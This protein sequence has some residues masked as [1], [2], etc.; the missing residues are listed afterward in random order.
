LGEKDAVVIMLSLTVLLF[1]KPLE[2]NTR[3]VW[4]VRDVLLYTVCP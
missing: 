1:N 2:K 3:S 4:S